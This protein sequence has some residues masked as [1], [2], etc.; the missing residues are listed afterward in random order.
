MDNLK[1]QSSV[2]L[3]LS[4]CALVTIV[5]R[6]ISFLVKIVTKPRLKTIG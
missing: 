5:T 3:K 4:I 2:F 1:K 6:D